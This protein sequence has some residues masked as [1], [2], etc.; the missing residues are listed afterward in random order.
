[1]KCRKCGAKAS[2]NMRQHKLALC[3]DHYLEWIP[4]QTE[5]FIKKYGMFRR[6]E[7]VLVAVSGGKDS[8][9]LWDILRRLGYDADGLYIGL[10]ID[11]GIG[12]S[13]ES[14]RLS[15]KFADENGLRL[16]V[17]D[18]A[19]EYGQTIPAL[20]EISH[21]GQGRPCAVCG[22]VKRHEMNRIAR[23]LGYDVL[24]TGHN[25]DD[26]AAVLFGNT[27]QW[28]EG[29]LRRQSPVLEESPGLARKVKPLCRFYEREMAAYALLRGIEYIYEECPF[30]EGATSIYYKELLNRLETDKPGAKLIFYLRFLEARESGLFAP[31]PESEAEL[32]P[33]PNCGQPTSTA[34]LCSF[35]RMVEKTKALDG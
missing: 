2:V 21:R 23:D 33:C 14:Q 9:S 34:D 32:H 4:E 24:A 16:H 27:L 25:L 26:E 1:M 7:K 12:Y 15:Q 17:V 22:L 19:K 28:S 11:G 5:R 13:S 20:A 3:K 18:V 8:L 35:C 30:A 6:G 10:G 31:Q 29:F